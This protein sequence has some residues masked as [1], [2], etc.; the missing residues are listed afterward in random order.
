MR[1]VSIGQKLDRHPYVNA[2]GGLDHLWTSLDEPLW[3]PMTT[4]KHLHIGELVLLI[5]GLASWPMARPMSGLGLNSTSSYKGVII[6]LCPILGTLLRWGQRLM[7]PRRLAS[8]EEQRD[9]SGC[10]RKGLGVVSGMISVMAARI[11]V[12]WEWY[13]GHSR[14][15][16]VVVARVRRR[17]CASAHVGIHRR[18]GEK[19]MRWKCHVSPVSEPLSGGPNVGEPFARSL[20]R[21]SFWGIDWSLVSVT[22]FGRMFPALVIALLLS[23]GS[24]AMKI[25]PTSLAA[26]SAF[27][28]RPAQRFF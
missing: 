23:V 27:I 9:L 14:I 5:L 26:W 1:C 4:L 2:D 21:C 3:A 16:A 12:S 13:G 22:A 25:G 28:V 15:S 18:A 20:I 24:P 11:C 7:M 8:I 19:W 10:D 17:R 6:S